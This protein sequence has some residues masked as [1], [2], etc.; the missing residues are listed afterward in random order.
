[1]AERPVENSRLRLFGSLIGGGFAVIGLVPLIPGGDAPWIWPLALGI[2]GLA[3]SLIFPQTVRPAF[4]AWVALGE[5]MPR[6]NTHI[7]LTLFY[8]AIVP[9]GFVLRL[10]R[11]DLMPRH[12]DPKAETYRVP[13]MKR[14]ASHMQRQ[15]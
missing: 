5:F 12:F 1:M 7:I 14:P 13:R 8:V 11:K 3:A 10:V 9:I 6:V 15:Y 2:A 4:R